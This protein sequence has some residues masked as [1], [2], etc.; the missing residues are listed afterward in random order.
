MVAKAFIPNLE[1]KPCVNHKDLNKRNNTVGNL[2]WCTYKENSEHASE[3]GVMVSKKG[4]ESNLSRYTES[5]VRHVYC[6]CRDGWSQSRA[7]DVMGMPRATVAS[8]MQ[9][10]SWK[11]VT[12]K[13]DAEVH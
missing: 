11:H 3:N 10:V 4:E 12:D 8:I 13:I 1:D 9:K 7:G 2:E 5:Q 6:L